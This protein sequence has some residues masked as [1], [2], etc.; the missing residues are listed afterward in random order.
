MRRGY[1]EEPSVKMDPEEEKKMVEQLTAFRKQAT[2]ELNEGDVVED[3]MVSVMRSV[4]RK[5]GSWYQVPKDLP[6]DD[7]QQA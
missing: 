6:D 2:I 7:D 3:E 4:R 5:R 1:R